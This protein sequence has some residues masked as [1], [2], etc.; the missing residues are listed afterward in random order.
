MIGDEEGEK[1][2]NDDANPFRNG[3]ADYLGHRLRGHWDIALVRDE[4]HF[5]TEST[6]SY[7]E[8]YRFVRKYFVNLL[9]VDVNHNR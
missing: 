2:E 4:C 7:N 5:G 9:D 6:T 3:D 1:I 8:F